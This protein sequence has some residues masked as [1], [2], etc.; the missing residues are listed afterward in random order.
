[1]QMK[2][3]VLCSKAFAGLQKLSYTTNLNLMYTIIKTLKK[4]KR[5]EEVT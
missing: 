1:M 2:S 3:K 5:Y 4:Q